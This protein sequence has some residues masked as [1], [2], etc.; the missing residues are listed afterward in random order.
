MRVLITLA[1]LTSS[2]AA[3]TTWYVDAQAVAPGLGTPVEP[4][5]S[6]QYA[7]S[8]PSTLSGDRIV[9]APG[10]YAEHV[11]FGSKRLALESTGGPRVTVIRSVADG[12]VVD[13]RYFGPG[14]PVRLEGF[15]VQG[16]PSHSTIGVDL[17]NT[18]MRRCIVHGHRQ[19]PGSSLGAGV[20]FDD[21]S[22]VLACTIVDNWRG[23]AEA[24]FGGA[25]EVRDSIVA[26]NPGGDVAVDP[27]VVTFA[28]TLVEEGLSTQSGPGNLDGD[29]WLWSTELFD[30]APAP[31]SAVIDSGDPAAPLDPDGSRRD[32]GALAF[33]PG[34]AP[35][36]SVYCT[37]KLNSLGCAPSIGAVGSARVSG[38]PFVITCSAQL[39]QRSGLLFYGYQRQALAYQ[40]GWLCVRAPVRRTPLLQSGGSTGGNDCTGS[41]SFDFDA[42]LQS[43]VDPALTPGAMVFAQYWSR[44]SAVSFGTVR[45]DA[46]SFGVGL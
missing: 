36:P 11:V 21:F 38:S 33:D 3:Q 1:L 44:D 13:A 27:K 5:T 20:R 2:A 45:S 35:A 32:M 39:N 43:G 26:G 34:Y 31:G 10:A 9:V 17:A 41:F 12:A 8:Q 6:I 19:L 30:F 7:I 16:N 25:G 4:Y 28:Y 24:G 46:L 42:W 37:S 15:T 40:G 18:L 22:S 14:G 29:P 23:L